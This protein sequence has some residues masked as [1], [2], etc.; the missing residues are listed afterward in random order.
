MGLFNKKTTKEEEPKVAVEKVV[1][2][3]DEARTAKTGKTVK[4]AKTG[5]EKNSAKASVYGVLIAPLL[6][7]KTASGEASNQ[8]VFAVD[9]KTTKNEIKKA[10][11][12]RYGL[13]PLSVNVSNVRGKFVRF[14]QR[15]GKRK[16]WK[17]AII[18]LPKGKSINVYEGIK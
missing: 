9:A 4:I 11:E 18:T 16:N 15:F 14:G 2:A 8:Y 3:K 1:E 10:V 7:E 5:T 13:K 6:T 12:S 17:K